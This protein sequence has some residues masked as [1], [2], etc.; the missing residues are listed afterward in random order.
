MSIETILTLKQ[1]LCAGLP[2]RLPAMSPAQLAR[3]LNEVAADREEI[4]GPHRP[5]IH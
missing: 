2:C 5:A 1:R 4:H 3:L